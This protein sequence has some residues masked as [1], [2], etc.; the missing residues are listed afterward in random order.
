MLPRKQHTNMLHEALSSSSSDCNGSF[1]ALKHASL[2]V[3]MQLPKG[4]SRVPQ[5]LQ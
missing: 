2:Q 5:S 3:G 1:I 4:I